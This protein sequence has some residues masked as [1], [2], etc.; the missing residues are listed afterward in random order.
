MARTPST[1]LALGTRAPHFRLP[2][3][4]GTSHELPSPGQH[5]ATLVMFL[6]NHCPYVKHVAKGIADLA[7]EFEQQGIAVF[8]IMSNDIESYP[9]DRPELMAT[10]AVKWGWNF[11]YLY[12]ATQK[13]AQ[14][15]AAACTPDFF[16]FDRSLLLVYRG[17]M[18][19]ARPGNGVEVTGSDL[20]AAA[21]Q[22]LR[23][24]PVNAEQKPSL[25]CNIKWRAGNEPAYFQRA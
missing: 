9:D 22:V 23:G 13:T 15:Y 19:G 4:T 14:A 17:Q 21:K 5:P 6:S 12:D 2:S 24:L 18:D 20:R 1:M 11:P 7:R 8:G 25:G 10:E 16:L 3:A